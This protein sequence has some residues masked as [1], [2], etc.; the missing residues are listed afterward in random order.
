MAVMRPSWLVPMRMRWIVAGRC[1][2]LLGTMGRANATFTGRPAAFAPRAAI[3]ASERTNSLAPKPP[4]MNGE[5]RRTF[6]FGMPRVRATS[7]TPHA[8]IW[9]DVHNVR[10]SPS[11][12]AI[13]ACG[14]IMQW[15]WSGVV[16]V[17]SNF[18]GAAANAASKSPTW[19]R[20]GPVCGV[21]R[22]S[23]AVSL[24]AARS[25]RPSSGA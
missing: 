22:V 13:E 12:A 18:T 2:V 19:L 21:L 11:Q 7:P 25:K 4:P 5:T 17:A 1:V 9:L 15:D 16:Y 10:R 6:F 24:A 20:G 3:T 8:I 23:G 14:S